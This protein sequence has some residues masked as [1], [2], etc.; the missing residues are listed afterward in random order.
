MRSY[1]ALFS[2]R[3]VSRPPNQD[4]TRAVIRMTLIVGLKRFGNVAIAADS[5]ATDLH[6][7]QLRP[8]FM[9]TGIFAPGCI[10]GICGSWDRAL[11]F[12]DAAQARGPFNTPTEAWAAIEAVTAGY[13]RALDGKT[14]QEGESEQFEILF[15]TRHSGEPT[16]YLLSSTRR[17][18]TPAPPG[19]SCCVLGKAKVPLGD[20]LHQLVSTDLSHVGLADTAKVFEGRFR[21]IDYPYLLVFFL[22][23][24]SMS[25]FGA[26][27]LFAAQTGGIFNF[28]QQDAH[29]EFRQRPSLYLLGARDSDGNGY[30]VRQRTAFD[31]DRILGD[32]MIAYEK[33]LGVKGRWAFCTSN[34]TGHT[35]HIDLAE[36][37]RLRVD[38]RDRHLR[39]PPYYFLGAGVIH[40]NDFVCFDFFDGTHIDA[41]LVDFVNRR[42]EQG[43]TSILYPEYGL[44]KPYRV[45]FIPN[46]DRHVWVPP[47]ESE[48]SR[49][50]APDPSA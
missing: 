2:P 17:D 1:A 49:E 5:I 28:I 40:N 32:V 30:L 14:W 4:T 26:E 29:S 45:S 34:R 15:S 8:E 43:I 6:T 3:A 38:M 20:V 24:Y 23:Q 16:M 11:D 37:E 47:L 9:K 19:K 33:W 7:G 50:A 48:S 22:H 18:L 10:Y 41:D 46:G 31:R 39:M 36:E 13:A 25:D 44:P 21:T 12:L 35:V 42:L 27:Q